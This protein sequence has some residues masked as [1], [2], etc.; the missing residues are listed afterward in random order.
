MG[1]VKMR[2]GVSLVRE[3]VRVYLKR[4]WVNRFFCETRQQVSVRTAALCSSVF[5]LWCVTVRSDDNYE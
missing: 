1:M 4:R 3:G 5:L 2:N